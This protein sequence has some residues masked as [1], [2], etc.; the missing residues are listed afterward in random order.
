MNLQVV[1]E[2]YCPQ[3]QVFS[4]LK[5]TIHAPEFQTHAHKCSTSTSAIAVAPLESD[6]KGRSR[7][8]RVLCLV[9]SGAKG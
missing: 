7:S 9:R 5:N 1:R 3:R 8:Q 4:I 6:C 2:M